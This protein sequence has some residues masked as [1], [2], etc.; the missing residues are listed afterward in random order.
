MTDC[1][2]LSRRLEEKIDRDRTLLPAQKDAAFSSAALTLVSAGAGTGKTHTLAWRFIRALLRD[3]VSPG[4]ILTLTFTEKAAREMADRIGSLF[5][6]LRPH[7]DPDGDLLGA[8]AEELPEAQISTI[9]SFALNILREEALFL[10]SGPAARPIAPP[11][12]SRF[13][14][15]AEDALDGLDI[16]W[17]HRSL[18][19]G[20]TAEEILGDSLDDLPSLVN[21]YGPGKLL[22]F[23]LSLADLME[24]RGASPEDL[25][26]AAADD[27]F[28]APVAEAIKEQWAP[29]ALKV[30]RIWLDE[31]L[32]RLRGKITGGGAFRERVENFH[33]FYAGV[34]RADLDREGL[35]DFAAKLHGDLLKNLS[36]VNSGAGRAVEELLGKKLTEHR[37]QFKALWEGLSFLDGEGERNFPRLRRG[38]LSLAAMIWLCYREYRRRRGLL[39][40]DDMIRLAAETAQAQRDGRPVRTYN[41]ILVD[42]FQDTNPLQEGLIRSVAGDESRRFLV[43]DLKQS[44]YR[45]RHA[46]PTLFGGLINR[47]FDG[48]RYVPLQINFRTR[49]SLLN[50]V[51]EQ[52]GRIWRQGLSPALKQNYEDLLFPE[53]QALKEKRELTEL[54]PVD[55]V[56][57]YPINSESGKEKI[58][59]VRTRVARGLAVKLRNCLGLPIWDKGAGKM[60]PA[61]WGDMAILVPTRTSYPALDK[62]LRSEEAIPTAFEKDKDYF[63]RGEVGDLGAVI[64]ALAFPNDRKALM[65]YLCTP[66]SGLSMEEAL[67]LLPDGETL[68]ARYPKGAAR[69][70]ALRKE[71]RYGGLFPALCTL[72]RDQAFLKYYP[73][74]NRRS[75]LANLRRALDLVREYE[76]IFGADP[77][78]CARYF[79]SLS[80]GSAVT[81]TSPLGDGEDVVRVMTIHSA[82]GLEFPIVAVMDLNQGPGGRGGA[83]ES[84]T[85]CPALGVGASSY[86]WE[87]MEEG[88]ENKSRTG[89]LARFLERASAEEEWERLFYVACTRARD[90]LILCSPCGLD[91][92]GNPAPKEG[93][94][95]S[96]VG[97]EFLPSKGDGN[98]KELDKPG[99]GKEQDI[100]SIQW[101]PRPEGTGRRYERLSATSFALFQWCP[102]AWRMK[103]RQGLE[104]T[105]ELPSSEEYGGADLGSLAHW[106]LARWDFTPE[107]L[108]RFFAPQMANPIPPRLRPSWNDEGERKALRQWLLTT[109]ESAA[110]KRLGALAA[111]NNLSREVPFRVSMADGP[112]LTGSM[113]VL[114]REGDRV[115]IRDYKITAGGEDPLQGEAPSWKDLYRAQLLFYGWAARSVFGPAD[116]DIRL[117]HLRTGEEGD[118]VAP[119]GSWEEV[120]ES[121]RKTA[122]KAA[123]GPYPPL[124]DRCPRCFYRMDCPYR[125]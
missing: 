49:A 94:W 93:S 59:S 92:E 81:E 17:F 52:F 99:E 43:G 40:F 95:L 110:G 33:K 64:T 102:A 96:M 4:D 14:L 100:P 37:N 32:P 106:I 42:E 80:A 120:G 48:D 25:A 58:S 75:A 12:E 44:I 10:P 28:F 104:L 111:G 24:S 117:I 11:E 7:L 78:G 71:A 2:L 88:E 83:G 67:S 31:V 19:E 35:L 5:N 13:V 89:A 121:I 46:D 73:G 79:A 86:P 23:A 113:D 63:G 68:E 90:S 108:G 123:Q 53:D 85:P 107:G 115:F 84:L 57:R 101:V 41:E 116:W 36:G 114:W 3:G 55:W 105:W 47:K 74:W 60:R 98:Q 16:E 8:I 26:A 62:V 27:R 18:P 109:A 66:F 118:L 54:P 77:A 56:V 72:L 22:N 38:L 1:N 6:S 45:F 76:V 61:S 50:W 119:E 69:L 97:E 82:K 39:S 34:R 122:F 124:R 20:W 65:G 125:G 103:F 112:A 91:K 87:W 15:R 29:E 30:A 70:D 9:H 51:N 21:R